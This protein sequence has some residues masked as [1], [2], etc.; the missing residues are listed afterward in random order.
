[1][2]QPKIDLEQL[3][4]LAAEEENRRKKIQA[5][6]EAEADHQ[7]EED[8]K[9]IAQKVIQEIPGILEKSAREIG[10][11]SAY[12]MTHIKTLAQKKAAKI[13]VAYCQQQ[14]M[15]AEVKEESDETYGHYE[16]IFVSY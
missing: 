9:P 15:K 6:R 12:V 14:G 10:L 4:K 16:S 11:T 2:E 1:M 3:R 13:V 5:I 7:A 8:A